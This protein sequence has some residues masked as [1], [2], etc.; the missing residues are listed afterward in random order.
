MRGCVTLRHDTT[1][2]DGGGVRKNSVTLSFNLSRDLSR[3]VSVQADAVTTS[4][5]V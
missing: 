2:N 1:R 5:I 4:P 3:P